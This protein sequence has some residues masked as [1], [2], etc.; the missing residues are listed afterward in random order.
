M[1]SPKNDKIA[2]ASRSFSKNPILRAELLERYPAVTFNETGKVL[3]GEELV[4]FLKGHDKAIVG[5]ETINEEILKSVPEIKGFSKYGVG[6]DMIDLDSLI[7]NRVLLGWTGGVNRRSVAELAL[8][9]ALLLVRSVHQSHTKLINREWTQVKG[10][11][12]TRKNI[13]IIGCGHV[14]KDL[15]RLLQPFKCRI[16]VNDIQ[17]YPEFYREHSI[18]EMKLEELLSE[19]DV[20][21]I[22]VPLDSSTRNLLNE[23]RLLKMK[24]GAI[25]L[26]TARGNIVDEVALKKLLV[27]GHIAGAG[28]DVYGI[29]PPTDPELLNHPNFYGTPHMGGSSVEAVLAMGRSAIANLDHLRPASE[30]LP[31]A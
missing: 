31:P 16:L 9:F 1:I 13:G 30:F 15:V 5:L 10:H 8:T 2:V 24:K 18:I 26:N 12:L 4:S 11:E 21:S 19:A 3:H 25:L 22:H 7:K 23:T 17:N 20:V 6:L 14:G 29:E 28:F 27:S